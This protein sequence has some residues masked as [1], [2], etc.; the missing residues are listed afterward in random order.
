[1]RK[2]TSQRKAKDDSPPDI[3]QL[4]RKHGVTPMTNLERFR[5][6]WPGD[7][8]DGFDETIRALRKE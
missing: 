1:M 3:I 6:T 7:P 5:G 8:D 4:A 2:Q